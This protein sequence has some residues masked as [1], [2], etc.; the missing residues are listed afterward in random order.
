MS[1]TS[2]TGLTMRRS[3]G[4][5]AVVATIAWLIASIAWGRVPE[6]QPVSKRTHE[7]VNLECRDEVS[8]RLV[9]LFANGTVRVK[10]GLKDE[11]QMLLAELDP[12]TL[13][14][15]IDRFTELDYSEIDRQQILPTEGTW[16]ATCELMLDFP[17]DANFGPQTMA[18][19]RFDSLPLNLKRAVELTDELAAKAEPADLEQLP[20]NYQP[21]IGDVLRRRD[22]QVFSVLGKT[23]DGKGLEL[24]STQDPLTLFV[25]IDDLRREFI[26]LISRRP[27][28]G[29]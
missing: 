26:A 22:G 13:Q 19:S 7:L 21:K 28:F 23:S 29:Q 25:A 11:Q 15:Y 14:G 27:R 1:R 16:V 17:G 8:R 6:E 18:F 9:T 5:M 10:E 4:A 3:C 2:V 12:V 20:L 24:E